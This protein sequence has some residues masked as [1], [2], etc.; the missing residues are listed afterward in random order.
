MNGTDIY[1]GDPKMILGPNGSYFEY[2]GGQPIMDRGIENSISIDLGTKS[3]GV[4]SHQKGW[5]GNYLMLD[6]AQRIGTD[7]QDTFQNSPINLRGLSLREQATKKAL[8]GK[9]YGE[10]KPD[11]SNPVSDKVVNKITV[12]PPSGTFK[13]FTVFSQLWQFQISDPANE[14]ISKEN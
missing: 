9:V 11:V 1:E 5:I 6:P 8:S 13:I 2:R 3:K 14:R 10:I 4:N 7:Y 12:S